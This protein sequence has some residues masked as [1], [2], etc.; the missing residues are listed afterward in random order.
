MNSPLATVILWILMGF[1][2]SLCAETVSWWRFETDD[3]A[4]AQGLSNPNEIGGEPALISN[5]AV[6]GTQAP[7]LFAEEVP[8]PQVPNTASV[9]SATQGGVAGIF[10]SAAYSSTLDVESITVEFWVRTTES[11]AGFIARTTDPSVAGEQGSITDGFRIVD[12]NSVRVDFWTAETRRNGT[13]RTGGRASRR[14]AQTTLD[15]GVSINDGDWHYIAFR[16]DAATGTARLTVGFN[17]TEVDLN[18]GRVMYWGGSRPGDESPTVTMGYRLDGNSGN[19]TG[20]LD[21]VRFTDQFEDNNDLLSPIPEPGTILMASLV[22]IFAFYGEWR[23]RV[24]AK[25]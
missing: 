18:D 22:A 25:A 8:G 7:D 11:D 24:S 5:N 20:T 19:N 16:Y 9:R 13:Y 1:A 4:S 21:E 6:L 10:G 12:P 15:S 17:E 14:P 2:G 23:R 3:D